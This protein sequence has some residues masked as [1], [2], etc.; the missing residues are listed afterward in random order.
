MTA[1]SRQA[2]ALGRELSALTG[3]RV[4]I[5]YRG[6]ASGSPSRTAALRRAMGDLITQQFDT[7][8]YPDLQREKMVGYGRHCSPPG[9]IPLRRRR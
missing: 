4:E 5:R 3:A 1:R 7:G 2:Q 9:L 8:R 6:P